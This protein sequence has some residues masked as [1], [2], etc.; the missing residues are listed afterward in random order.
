MGGSA[1]DEIVYSN[2]TITA[3]N[4]KSTDFPDTVTP[5]RDGWKAF[6]RSGS[7]T[8]ILGGSGD[9]RLTGFYSGGSYYLLAGYTS[10]KDFPT[11]SPTGNPPQAEY[12]GGATDGFLAFFGPSLSTGANNFVSYYGT[13][14]DDRITAM[15]GAFGFTAF[16][17]WTTDRG[18]KTG[19]TISG[20]SVPSQIQDG[21]GGGQDGFVV[22]FSFSSNYLFLNTLRYF[23]GSG[24][25][26]PQSITVANAIS[27]SGYFIAGETNS[28][29]LPGL[30]TASTAPSGSSDAFIT[31][32]LTSFG[33]PI[34]ILYG[35]SGADRATG[36]STAGN[37]VAVGLTGVTSSTDLPLKNAAQATYGGGDSDA[38]VALISGDL[39][40]ILNATYVGGSGADE[41]TSASTDSAG[42]WF[43]GGWTASPDFP[44][45]SNAVQGAYG[46]GPDDAFLLHYDADGNLEQSTFFGGS[47]SDR[48][49]SVSSQVAFQALIAG[50]TT[51][52]DLPLQNAL[53]MDLH[54]PS[55]G[56]MASIST[57]LILAPRV[58]GSARAPS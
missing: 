47:G 41:A 34:S 28:A 37:G 33:S 25:D 23:G 10:S 8:L 6:Y 53:Q 40:Q 50:S 51:S 45:S 18:L 3:G 30:T 58:A 39:T 35:G 11:S 26:R 55:D 17:G 32:Y 15:T 21:P 19:S 12:A 57:K 24:D 1:D 2:G 14:G 13:P 52:P 56:F 16:T 49:L 43:V 44:V 9:D 54:G 4:T 46:G 20:W 36:I 42:G 29:D 22:T 7:Y 5:K 31:R 38:F 27:A 48:V